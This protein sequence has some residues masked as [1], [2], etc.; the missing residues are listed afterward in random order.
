MRHA[1]PLRVHDRGTSKESLELH[2]CL[3]HTPPT[4][5]AVLLL[6]D[7]EEGR[8]DHFDSPR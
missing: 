2:P 5:L 7:D 4:Q 8:N 1:R 6:V 3:P